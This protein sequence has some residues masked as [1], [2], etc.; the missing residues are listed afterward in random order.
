[1]RPL[2]KIHSQIAKQEP[3]EI[4]VLQFLQAWSVCKLLLNWAS[5]WDF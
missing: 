4:V 3:P 5:A 2:V 1:M